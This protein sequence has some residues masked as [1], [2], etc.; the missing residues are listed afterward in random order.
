MAPHGFRRTLR[1]ADFREVNQSPDPP[2]T[3][4][5]VAPFR[6][7]NFI[8]RKRAG[9]KYA[10]DPHSL[11]TTVS[12]DSQASWRVK[13]QQTADLLRHEQGHYN[14]SALASRDLLAD[15]LAIEGDDVAE[16]QSAANDLVT[17]EQQLV[18]QV[19]DAYDEDVNCGTQHGTLAPKQ[20][21]WDL[22]INNLMNQ[23]SGR[24][25][26][27]ATCPATP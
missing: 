6:T 25:D 21:Q 11:T 13:G 19:N 3:A 8:I 7:S 23:S 5:T 4:R 22:R 2:H 27:L 14:I 17:A 26:A 12:I 1:W 20:A 18:N 16:V 15:L 10:I 24:L 9:G